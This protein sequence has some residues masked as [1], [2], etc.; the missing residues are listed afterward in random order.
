[1]LPLNPYD[2]DS[3]MAECG[4]ITPIVLREAMDAGFDLY[5]R[6]RDLDPAAHVDYTATTRANML[7]NRMYPVLAALVEVADPEG[8]HLRTRWTD[9]NVARELFIGGDI[10]AKM[11][12]VK[13]RVHP[14]KPSDDPE[15]VDLVDIG[16][17]EGGLP[18]NIPTQRVLAQLSPQAFTG[19]Q[20][21]IDGVPAVQIP[22]DGS[23]RLCLIARFDLDATEHR[24]E[25][26]QVGLYTASHS[27][28]TRPLMVLPLD[29]IAT[30][31]S[32]LAEQVEL[33]RQARIA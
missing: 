13:D 20:L 29:V 27:I 7:V 23:N 33:L 1:M 8:R 22:D 15:L 10:Y 26:C 31:S 32:P 21:T 3:V 11:K 16:I 14:P 2:E 24:L 17:A 28:W 30:I 12:R 25:R 18:A 6:N 4:E 5:R 9:N 19:R